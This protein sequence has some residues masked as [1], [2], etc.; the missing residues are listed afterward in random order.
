MK[1]KITPVNEVVTDIEYQCKA[2]DKS[3]MYHLSDVHLDSPFCDRKLLTQHLKLAEETKS[4]VLIAGDIFDS[5][6]THDDPRRRPEELKEEYRVSHYLDAIV[7]DAAKFFLQF[8]VQYIMGIGNHE[9]V[10][11]R[12]MNTGLIDRL[13]H[14]IN[15]Q[16]G[17]AVGMGYGGYLRL[18][19]RYQNGKAGYQKTIYFH[20]GRSSSAE[21]T[22]GVIQSNRQ[23]VYLYDVD[24]VQNGH[25]HEAWILPVARARL[26]KS[27][28]PYND[29]LW[30]MM[31]PGYKTSGMETKETFGYG[32]ERHPAP[33]PKGCVKVEYIFSKNE[34]ITPNPIPMFVG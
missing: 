19:F 27:G 24:L 28:E 22:R 10:I 30:F 9:S 2:T 25:L 34:G 7:L 1:P 33:K 18:F 23:A 31:T 3:T 21:V 16:G 6:Q 20:H 13:V 5:M 15:T 12:K 32:Q 11:L 4:P 26:S 17:E 29:L 8:K 14:D